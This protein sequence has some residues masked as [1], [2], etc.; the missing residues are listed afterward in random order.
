MNILVLSWRGV[1]HPNAGGAEVSTFEHARGWVKMGHRVTLFTSYFPNAK[2]EEIS[3]GVEIKRYGRQ[4]FGVQLEAF[5]WYLFK[6][7]EKFDLVIDEFHGIPFFTPFYVRVKK[8]GFIHE[9]AKEVW[10][11][12]PWPKPYNIFPAVIGTL[13]EPLIFKFYKKV[14]FMTVSDSTKKDLIAWG[15]PKSEITVVHNGV[16]IPKNLKEFDKE[17]ELTLIFLGALSKDKGIEDALAAF[18]C[19]YTKNKNSKLW[20]VGKSDKEYLKKLK[21][22]AEKLEIND[23]VTFYDFVTEEKKFELLSRAHLLINTSTREGWGLV[24]IEAAWM[25]TPTV[26]YNVPGLRDSIVDG[27]TGILCNPDPNSCAKDILFLMKDN[28]KYQ[29]FQVNSRKWAEGFSWKKSVQNSLKLIKKLSMV[30]Q[31]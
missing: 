31:K 13:F 10:M 7:H 18:A 29:A 14:P 3:D 22:L 16:T 2:K 9:V 27:K 19:V 28:K 23:R 4:M 11:L 25:G 12:N 1:K 30:D 17:K 24:V 21:L 15:I 5:V 8:M 20:V 26:G 6:N